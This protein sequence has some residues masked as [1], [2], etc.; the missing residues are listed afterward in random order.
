MGC[1]VAWR[2]LR[3]E[4]GDR[5]PAPFALHRPLARLVCR[6]RRRRMGPPQRRRPMGASPY[7]PTLECGHI[8]S[9]AKAQELARSH[10]SEVQVLNSRA[11]FWPMWHG[12]EIEKTHETDEHNFV[13]S[14]QYA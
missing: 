6:F 10:T 2:D 12:N 14:G 4:R 8:K 3:I 7:Y 11:F 5:L 13:K 1:V 9:S